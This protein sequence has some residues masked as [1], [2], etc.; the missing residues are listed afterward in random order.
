MCLRRREWEAEVG[1]GGR[2]E[3]SGPSRT[4]GGQSREGE[5]CLA[6]RAGAVNRPEAGSGQA[7]VL[8]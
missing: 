5:S 3:G 2:G 7:P 4:E 6:E 1:K 8:P